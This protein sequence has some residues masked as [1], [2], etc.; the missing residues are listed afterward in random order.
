MGVKEANLRWVVKAGGGGALPTRTCALNLA[1][2]SWQWS[3]SSWL[4]LLSL[5]GHLQ[6]LLLG[7]I[8]LWAC[9]VVSCISAT[10]WLSLYQLYL[11]FIYFF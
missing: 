4:I 3:H 9:G 5:H 8:P 11:F 7:G 6:D 10:P 2:L 1:L